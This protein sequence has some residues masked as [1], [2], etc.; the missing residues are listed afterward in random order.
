MSFLKYIFTTISQNSNA[1]KVQAFDGF[2]K[3]DESVLDFGCGDLA[4]AAVLLK[5]YPKLKI[6]GVDVVDFSKKPKNIQYVSYNGSKLP[7]KNN[8]FDT[9]ISFYVFHH[10]PSAAASFKECARV[11]RG[12]IVFVESVYRYPWE[13]PFMKL[14]DWIYNK[15][16]SESVPLSYQFLSYKG[17]QKVFIENN[18]KIKKSKRIKQIFLPEILPIGISY[19]FELAKTK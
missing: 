14:L 17:W 16:K 5:K 19:V 6:T 9:V 10:C 4:L 13:R 2:L 11:A 18:I 12:R 3:G 1:W 7:F 8:S 15:V